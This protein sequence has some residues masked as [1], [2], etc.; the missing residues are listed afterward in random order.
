M[1]FHIGTLIFYDFIWVTL[2]FIQFFTET[3]HIWLHLDGHVSLFVIGAKD[4]SI[5]G[6]DGIMDSSFPNG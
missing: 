2:L 5:E 3:S 1:I 4:M 6:L